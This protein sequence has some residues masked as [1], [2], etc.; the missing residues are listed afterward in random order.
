M[1]QEKEVLRMAW[2]FSGELSVSRQIVDRLRSDI[3]NG[4]YPPG[5]QF[6]TV[7]SL[8]LEA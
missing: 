1:V 2:K 6:P 5:G 8:A 3:L 7:R 4:K